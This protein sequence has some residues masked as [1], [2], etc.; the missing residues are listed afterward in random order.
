VCFGTRGVDLFMSHDVE[1]LD[2]AGGVFNP[3]AQGNGGVGEKK[4]Y[5]YSSSCDFLVQPILLVNE[6]K[7]AQ[8][9]PDATTRHLRIERT[10]DAISYSQRG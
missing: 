8:S 1:T 4:G 7:M 3:G 6:H 5:I 2:D 9:S 10:R